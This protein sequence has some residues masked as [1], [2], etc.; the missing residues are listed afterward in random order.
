MKTLNVLPVSVLVRALYKTRKPSSIEIFGA[1]ICAV[2]TGTSTV[3]HHPIKYLF[4][5]ARMSGPL[6]HDEILSAAIAGLS[7]EELCDRKNEIEQRLQEIQIVEPSKK[8]PRTTADCAS[9]DVVANIVPILAKADTHWDFC[10]KEMMWLAADFLS[11]RK[12]QLT[13]AKKLATGVSGFHATKESRRVRALAEAELQ[14]RRL[15]GKIGREVRTWWTKIER[16]IAYKQKLEADSERRRAMNQQLVDLVK[17]TE[18]YGRSLSAVQESDDDAHILTIEEALAGSNVRRVQ[19]PTDYARLAIAADDYEIYGE[20]TEDSGSDGSFVLGSEPDDDDETT[21]REAEELETQ[22]RRRGLRHCDGDDD[23]SYMADPDEIERLQEES[24]MDINLVLERMREEASKIPEVEEADTADLIT[25]ASDE[26]QPKQVTFALD[27]KPEGDSSQ[28]A[29]KPDPGNDADDDGDASDVED[30]RDDTSDGS[31][32]FVG[33]LDA[34][35]DET[36][37]E[38]EER[39]GREMSVTD[40]ISMLQREGEMSVDELRKLYAIPD[41]AERSEKEDNSGDDESS[42]NLSRK[43]SVKQYETL[44]SADDNEDQD[45][46]QPDSTEVDD[47]TT[48]EAEERLGREMS[49][50]EEINLLQKEGEIPV[51]QLRAMYASMDNGGNNSDDNLDDDEG[52][53][54]QINSTESETNDD[55]INILLDSGINDDSAADEFRPEDEVDDETT[56]EAEERLGRD[57]S[58]E[59]ELALLKRESEMS[60]EELRQVYQGI[61]EE[62]ES[63]GDEENPEVFSDHSSANGNDDG[64]EEFVDDENL[65]DDETTMEAEEQLGREI[66]ID[67]EIRILEHEGEMPIEKLRAIYGHENNTINDGGKEIDRRTGSKRKIFALPNQNTTQ[68]MSEDEG[69]VALQTLNE[70]EEKLRKTLATRPF[71]MSSWVH[72]REYQQI[73]LNWLVSIQSRRLN[74]ILADEMVRLLQCH[75]TSCRNESQFSFFSVFRV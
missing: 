73:G 61:A 59:E 46:F 54:D 43:G 57:M 39:L 23:R 60:V 63:I 29:V 44:F 19:Q 35:D 37:I 6:T 40:E 67:D 69:L 53:D 18:R 33:N 52:D 71:L 51:E 28:P 74:G 48:L 41:E 26:K 49:Y 1:L 75:S 25:D 11:E 55:N 68:S 31:E 17:Q 32:E 64:S 65:V 4:P 13:M 56:M 22:E 36:T 20:S 34:V 47:E 24:I 58:Y 27:S 5:Q 10:M 21:L 70:M 72:M 15:A 50:D 42:E 8:R 16:V 30:F 38:A 12:R 7:K 2:V 66:S 14:R 3:I 9:I 62:E 45:E